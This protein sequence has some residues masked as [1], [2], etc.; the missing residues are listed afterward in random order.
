MTDTTD[1]DPILR[2]DDLRRERLATW[3]DAARRPCFEPLLEPGDGTPDDAKMGGTPLGASPVCKGCQ[4][5]MVL[6]LQL[7]P[8]TL[9]EGAPLV[10]E[11]PL[12]VFHCGNHDCDH[13]DLTHA[14]GG[15][16]VRLRLGLPKASSRAT[17]AT[18][19]KAKPVARGQ[20]SRII[21]WKPGVDLPSS[22]DADAL[23]LDA[24]ELRLTQAQRSRGG[25][26]LGGY[27]SW[28]QAPQPASCPTCDA[29]MRFVF[30]L[31][32]RLVD[33]GDAGL[34]Y[35]H[36]CAKHPTKLA[37]SWSST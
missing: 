36:Q 37:F 6:L 15:T 10:G 3:L 5:T 19:K 26:K 23:R 35:V 28:I 30:Q 33:F 17:S 12:Q 22:G 8:A 29:P 4:R 24:K 18:S 11:G 21:G 25:D 16:G 7:D 34:G 2:S 1:L 32:A 13:G 27:P 31:S 14:P 9:P 20:A